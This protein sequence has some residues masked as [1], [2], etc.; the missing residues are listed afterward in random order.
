MRKEESQLLRIIFISILSFSILLISACNGE[1]T[2]DAEYDTTKKMVVDILQTDDGKKALSE[3]ME[4]E[5][6]K[7]QLI[8]ESDTVKKS[9]N[10]ALASKKGKEM[11]T[12]LFKDPAFVE[13]FSKSMAEEQ[14][15]LI[16]KLMNDSDYQKQMLELLQNPEIT[17][18]M[19]KVMKSQ[20]FRSHLEETIQQTLETPSFQA[21]MKET[22]LKAAEEQGK[23]EKQGQEGKNEGGGGQSQQQGGGQS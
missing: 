1:K 5:K 2:K 6:M 8:I 3:I 15:K 14:K 22:L 7:K 13:T 11:W 21:K 23:K 4:D 18:Q 9:L 17:D 12:N 20:Q 19:L 10:D 16:K